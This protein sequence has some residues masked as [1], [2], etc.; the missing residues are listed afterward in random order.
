MKIHYKYFFPL[1]F[2]LVI[3]MS[4][5]AAA[6]GGQEESG[7]DLVRQLIDAYN[8][9]DYQ[10][11]SELLSIAFQHMDKFPPADQK[12]I[13]Q[14]AA[15][16]AFQNGNS[17][18][19]ENHFW[20]LLEI[21]PTYTPDPVTTAPKLLTLFQKTKIEFLEDMNQRL[22]K[23]RVPEQKRD[24]PW[25]GILLPGWEQ[26]HRGYRSRAAVFIG[27]AAISAGGFVYSAI[28]AHNKKSSYE[29]AATPGAAA[30]F[31]DDYNQYYRQQYYFGYAFAAVWA[32]SQIDLSVWSHPDAT[33][34]LQAAGAQYTRFSPG[35]S[36]KI[37]F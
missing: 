33:L 8:R 36:L 1:I 25:R 22:Q 11:S 15:F 30:S 7:S 18:L 2:I 19:A 32:L 31:Y 9:F 26:W 29:E 5:G 28:Q 23:I 6:A 10:K 17:T 37:K 21:D 12:D 4:A 13:Y 3:G 34:R 24:I 35:L 14:Y 27:A 20:H 16:I